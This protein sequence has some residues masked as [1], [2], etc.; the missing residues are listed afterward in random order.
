MLLHPFMAVALLLAGVAVAVAS[1]CLSLMTGEGEWFQRSGSLF[2]L[3]SV[4]VEIQQSA[5]KQPE[6]SSFVFISDVPAAIR[7]PIS[8]VSKWL[9]RFAWGG[10]VIGTTIWG[11]GD[12]LF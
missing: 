4:L 1:A 8:A 9:H 11:Y 7:Q 5:I 6:G 10:I 2:V 3:F 12:L